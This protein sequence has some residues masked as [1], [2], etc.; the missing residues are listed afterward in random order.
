MLRYA[1]KQQGIW[2]PLGKGLLTYLSL[3]ISQGV[4]W[5][6]SRNT[7]RTLSYLKVSWDSPW[8]QLCRLTLWSLA[9]TTFMSRPLFT[10]YSALYSV[11]TLVFHSGLL[12]SI[13][14]LPYVYPQVIW[15]MTKCPFCCGSGDINK[16]L[17]HTRQVFYHWATS[18]G[19]PQNLVFYSDYVFCL[20]FWKHWPGVTNLGVSKMQHRAWHI[21]GVQ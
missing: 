16:G 13:T 20:F 10:L 9:S 6:L 17:V 18:P 11:M 12:S 14:F 15:S 8:T 1:D 4:E 21:L 7:S 3:L 2:E 19:L 5:D